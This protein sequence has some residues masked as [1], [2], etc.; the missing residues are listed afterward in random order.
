MEEIIKNPERQKKIA[1]EMADKEALFIAKISELFKLTAEGE[2]ESPLTQRFKEESLPIPSVKP[3]IWL[4]PK[5]QSMLSKT[6]LDETRKTRLAY[7]L[8]TESNMLNHYFSRAKNAEE[9]EKILGTRVN[10][11]FKAILKAAE[12]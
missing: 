6:L 7:I 8:E 10:F 3:G 1:K 11:Y 5:W 12:E 2:W 9:V 4:L